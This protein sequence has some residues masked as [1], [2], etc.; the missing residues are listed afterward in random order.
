MEV[1]RFLEPYGT[2]KTKSAGFRGAEDLNA[3]RITRLASGEQSNNCRDSS[4]G[5][6][7]GSGSP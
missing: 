5:L 7:F 1:E 3:G 6:D 2:V 4:P